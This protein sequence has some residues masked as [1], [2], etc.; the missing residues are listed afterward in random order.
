MAFLGLMPEKYPA[1]LSGSLVG[2]LRVSSC[3]HGYIEACT[4]GVTGCNAMFSLMPLGLLDVG[5]LAGELFLFLDVMVDGMFL[6]ESSARRKQLEV[7][8]PERRVVNKLGVI[9]GRARGRVKAHFGFA[10]LYHSLTRPLSK[11]RFL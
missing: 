5:L 7:E 9:N 11:H 2:Y 6:N 3:H 8:D 4:S 1:W 10:I